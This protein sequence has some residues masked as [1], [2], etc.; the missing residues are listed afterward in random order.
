MKN[1]NFISFKNELVDAIRSGRKWQTRRLLKP[2][3]TD[4]GAGWFGLKTTPTSVVKWNVLDGPAPIAQYMP[5]QPGNRPYVRE[6]YWKHP[7]GDIAIGNRPDVSWRYVNSMF[8]PKALSRCTIEITD[9]R[10]QQVRDIS[11]EDAR[12]EGMSPNWADD[13]LTGWNPEEHGFLPLN[14]E[15]LHGEDD[16]GVFY[17]ARDAFLATWDY[18]NPANPVESNPWVVAYTFENVTHA[19]QR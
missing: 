9:V 2:Q 12:A 10:V 11:E 6:S 5:F 14:W 16:E 8:M 13:Y 3:P 7:S 17:T 15:K 4:Y 18:L 1:R 19:N